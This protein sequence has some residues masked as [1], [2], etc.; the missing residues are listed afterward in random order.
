MISIAKVIF[1]IFL[2]V[3][4]QQ[5][6]LSNV[7]ILILITYHLIAYI[8]PIHQ[9]IF[10]FLNS[11]NIHH[12][13]TSFSNLFAPF[14]YLDNRHIQIETHN[15]GKFHQNHILE[16]CKAAHKV[17]CNCISDMYMSFYYLHY[18]ILWLHFPGCE[19]K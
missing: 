4:A 8:H 7:I 15:R 16:D 9:G 14:L 3:H 17:L 1:S 13:S 18:K 19:L 12:L 10:C 5:L 6:K 2:R 11:I